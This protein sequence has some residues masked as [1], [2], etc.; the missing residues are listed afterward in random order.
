MSADSINSDDWNSCLTG[1]Q[2][3]AWSLEDDISRIGSKAED[4]LTGIWGAE[5]RISER[6]SRWK[7]HSDPDSSDPLRRYQTPPPG[8]TSP[9]P[10]ADLYSQSIYQAEVGSDSWK[11]PESCNGPEQSDEEENSS[12]IMK[13]VECMPQDLFSFSQQEAEN[14]VKPAPAEPKTASEESSLETLN[15]SLIEPQEDSVAEDSVAEDS[16]VEDSIAEESIVE[17]SIVEETISSSSEA[18][19]STEENQSDFTPKLIVDPSKEETGSSFKHPLL[20]LSIGMSICGVGLVFGAQIMHNAAV[21]NP[22]KSL[23]IAGLIGLFASVVLQTVNR[24]GKH[25]TA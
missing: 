19:S 18:I 10:L 11:A 6:N 4:L 13:E 15:R 14:N 23:I 20:S 2:I 1:S 5:S 25:R 8:R 21:I 7:T 17:D 22:G 12:P 16:I 24:L 3:N 9:T